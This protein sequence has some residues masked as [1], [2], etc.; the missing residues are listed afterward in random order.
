MRLAARAA[1]I[2]LFEQQ[3]RRHQRGGQP[4]LG[5][6]ETS[7]RGSRET[8]RLAL[9]KVKDCVV[10]AD[11][12]N[13]AEHVELEAG[14]RSAAHQFLAPIGRVNAVGQQRHAVA[15]SHT[16]GHRSHGV[17]DI[18]LALEAKRGVVHPADLDAPFA[19][20]IA[21]QFQELLAQ[22]GGRLGL[23]GLKNEIAHRGARVGK[24]SG[25]PV[26]VGL[27]KIHAGA[28]RH[29]KIFQDTVL[30][31]R[32]RLRAQPF[33]IYFVGPQ[34]GMAVEIF[35]RRIVKQRDAGGKDARVEPAGPF[36]VAAH[37]LHDAVEDGSQGKRRTRAGNG[38]TERLCEKRRRGGRVE[39]H[40][41]SGIIRRGRTR[42]QSY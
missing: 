5:A 4:A 38:R 30:D 17:A 34:Q 3:R 26:S 15:I 20:G 27:L 41:A 24:K 19:A 9:H 13:A 25:A 2:N 18:I 12:G 37:L 33:L 32:N 39:K 10:V 16:F 1:N 22:V 35:F 7:Q 11:A 6:A 31:Q 8:Q 40:G 21:A 28:A 42:A 23:R 14:E 29:Q 36:A